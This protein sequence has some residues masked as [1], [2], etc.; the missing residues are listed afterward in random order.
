VRL[1]QDFARQG[2]LSLTFKISVFGSPGCGKSAM[3]NILNGAQRFNALSPSA[4]HQQDSPCYCRLENGTVIRLFFRE[5]NV[6]LAFEE[7]PKALFKNIHV[8][9]I[10]YNTLDTYSLIEHAKCFI[11]ELN[12]NAIPMVPF[13]DA[14]SMMPTQ[15]L[16]VGNRRKCSN[17]ASEDNGID[18]GHA[19]VPYESVAADLARARTLEEVCRSTVEWNGCFEVD[20]SSFSGVQTITK[21]VS[22]LCFRN[23]VKRG[24]VFPDP[25]QASSVDRFR[26]PHPERKRSN[27]LDRD[28]E[29]VDSNS[30][31]Q[32]CLI[33]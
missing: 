15:V 17:G 24:M 19:D 20:A 31:D 22:D 10:M 14:P 30:P 12:K 3:M 2:K 13:P 27:R 21:L 9:I 5:V 4:K 7:T 29:R 6:N 8:A 1:K 23:L 16:L 25:D 28:R 11:T 33:M 32:K 26:H 18:D